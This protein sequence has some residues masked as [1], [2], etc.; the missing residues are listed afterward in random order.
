MCIKTAIA[1]LL[2]DIGDNACDVMVHDLY[3]AFAKL[4]KR[5]GNL[6]SR[7]W[8]RYWI[9]PLDMFLVDMLFKVHLDIVGGT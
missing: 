1:S 3:Y 2:E 6:D 4:E 9:L 8:P 5:K 7:P